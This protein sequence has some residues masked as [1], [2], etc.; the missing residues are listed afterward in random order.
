MI[1]QTAQEWGAFCVAFAQY[2]SHL[3]RV[4][5][6]HVNSQSL[7]DE[8]KQVAQFY[9]RR[10]R[11]LLNQFPLEVGRTGQHRYQDLLELSA[12]SLAASYKRSTKIV[13]SFAQ[14]YQSTGDARRRGSC[15]SK[16]VAGRVNNYQYPC[17]IGSVR[18]S[19]LSTSRHRPRQ[20]RARFVPGAR[21]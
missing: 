20:Y 1:E 12:R 14:D 4:S 16:Y 17:E 11:P 13:G 9:F 2:V 5:A 3:D 6:R 15:Q 19:V 8:T 18:S 21:T 7:K 10:I